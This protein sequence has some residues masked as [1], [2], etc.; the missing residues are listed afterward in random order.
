MYKLVFYNDKNLYAKF[1][2]ERTKDVKSADAKKALELLEAMKEERK[3]IKNIYYKKDDLCFSVDDFDIV[4][5][6]KNNFI[7]DARFDFIFDE[8]KKRRFKLVK[9]AIK[10]TMVFSLASA[11]MV[12]GI[13][14]I[15]AKSQE[16]VVPYSSGI[17]YVDKDYENNNTL[18]NTEEKAEEILPLSYDVSEESKE[19]K[20]NF[21]A[22]KYLSNLGVLKEDEKLLSVKEKYGDVIR[23]YSDKYGVDYNLMCAIATQERG[24]HSDKIDDGGAIGL[25]QIQVSVWADEQIKVYNYESGNVE[26]IDIT[27]D[28]L[29]DVNFNIKVGCA[30][31]QNYFNQMNKNVL[32]ATQS[33]NMGPNSVK[34]MLSKH[35]KVTGKN[36]DEILE[37]ESDAGWLEYRNDVKDGKPEYDGDPEYIEHVFRYYET[38]KDNILETDFKSHV[39]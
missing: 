2:S 39:K 22:S 8:I 29:K 25:M 12:V 21:N 33:Y 11:L 28:K 5:R 36:I 34:K 38:N 37:D 17:H 35:S 31:Y 27:L 16:N 1:Y 15:K 3:K 13:A 23:K 24:V 6:N 32:A 20:D 4:L 14:S 18:Q 19:N 9:K 7:S 10:T 26:T 30:I